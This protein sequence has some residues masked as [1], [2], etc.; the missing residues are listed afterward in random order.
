MRYKKGIILKWLKRI[1]VY[2]IEGNL[3]SEEVPTE[4]VFGGMQGL[5]TLIGE[6]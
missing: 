2:D 6:N 5:P 1:R 3:I 4:Y